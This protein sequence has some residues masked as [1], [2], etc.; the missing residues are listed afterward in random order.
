MKC[1]Q[2]A[3]IKAKCAFVLSSISAF[4]SCSFSQFSFCFS[5]VLFSWECDLN[6]ST[7]TQVHKNNHIIH[8]LQAP[9]LSQYDC[10]SRIECSNKMRLTLSASCNFDNKK[11]EFQVSPEYLVTKAMQYALWFGWKSFSSDITREYCLF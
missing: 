2:C 5:V 7:S 10:N 8:C 4:I 9:S 11:K 3:I 1:R 6:T